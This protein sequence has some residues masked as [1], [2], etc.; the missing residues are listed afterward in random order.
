MGYAR[1]GRI[2][3]KHLNAAILN[4]KIKAASSCRVILCPSAVC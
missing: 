2:K 1:M 3:T 4:Q